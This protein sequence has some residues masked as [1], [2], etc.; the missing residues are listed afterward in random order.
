MKK[1][2]M[3]EDRDFKKSS[4][5]NNTH[6]FPCVEVARKNGMVAVRD[7]K[8]LSKGTLVFNRAEWRAFIGG[9]KKG[10]FDI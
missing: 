1:K 7:T 4:L 10:E 8:D 5:C 9:A 6:I 2:L 3:F